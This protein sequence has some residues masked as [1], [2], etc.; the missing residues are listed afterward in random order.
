MEITL[1]RFYTALYS[2]T[3]VLF[4]SILC[5][6][7]LLCYRGR[8]SVLY[9]AHF[10]NK[11][12][13]SVPIKGHFRFFAKVLQYTYSLR[14]ERLNICYIANAFLSDPWDCFILPLYIFS[15]GRVS[16]SYNLRAACLCV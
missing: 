2:L 14:S 13:M 12:K 6:K 5:H 11:S 1:L 10:F 16:E 3:S 9:L 4:I 15:F 7:T 8:G